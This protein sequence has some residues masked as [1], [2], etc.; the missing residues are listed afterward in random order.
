MIFPSRPNRQQLYQSLNAL[1]NLTEKAGTLDV[2]VE[3]H[4]A[5]GFDPIWLRNAVLEPLEEAD[6]E[7]ER[8]EWRS[9]EHHKP[10]GTG[11]L[12]RGKTKGGNTVATYV[13]YTLE[14]GSTVLIATDEPEGGL[15]R[16]SRKEGYATVPSKVG[17]E[18]AFASVKPSTVALRRQLGD[19]EAQEVE[20]TF[21]IKTIGEAGLF[22]I[23]KVGMEANFEVT[24]KWSNKPAD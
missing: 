21:G 8:E 16:A 14:D 20:I 1:G 18:E 7:V 22:V 13:E 12:A 9:I 19:L 23:G 15:V 2:T 24:L 11:V 6:I 17:F 3:A 10:A 4:V 5:Q